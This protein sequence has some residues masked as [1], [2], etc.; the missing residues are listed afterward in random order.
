MNLTERRRWN[1]LHG[2]FEQVPDG[3]NLNKPSKG[4]AWARWYARRDAKKN[5][6]SKERIKEN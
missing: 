2:K 4:G 5:Q 3:E 1:A 6:P